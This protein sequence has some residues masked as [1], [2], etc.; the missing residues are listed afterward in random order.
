MAAGGALAFA[1]VEYVLTLWAHQGATPLATKLR[2]VALVAM[3]SLYLFFVLALVLGGAIAVARLVRARFDPAAA[4]APGLFAPGTRQRLAG[5]VRPN[6]PALWAAVATGLV[7]LIVVQRAGAWAL[8]RFKEP[9]LTAGL[10]AASALA[11]TALAVPVFRLLA[12]GARAGAEAL[13]F[14]GPFNPLGRWRASG[15]ALAALVGGALAAAWYLVPPSRSVLPVRLVIS[16]CVIALGAGWGGYLRSRTRPSTLAA[17]HRKARARFVAACGGVLAFGTLVFWGAD[18]GTKYMA[19]TGSPALAKLVQVVRLSNDVDRDGFGSLLGEGD[20]APFSRAVNP[21]A[22]DKP[23]NQIDENCDGHDF[24]LADIVPP[25]GPHLPV[26]PGFQRDWNILLITIDALRYDHT[27]FGGYKDGPKKRDTTPR[28]AELVRDST[29]FTWA[30][31]PAA[32]T[33]ASIPA[34]L[35]SKYFHSGIAID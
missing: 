23:G 30:M 8:V 14:L 29:S 33:M 3:L 32:G 11:M 34:I 27:T 7:V 35:T 10:I 5:G 13:A 21:G 9:Q 16:A 1:P 12:I 15:I 28:L 25:P 24:S 4:T 18:L 19:I 20:C 2:L 26:P 6:V 17:S 31:A 22:R